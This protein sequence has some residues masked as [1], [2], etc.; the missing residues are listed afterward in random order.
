MQTLRYLLRK[1]FLQVFR[2]RMMVTQLLLMPIIQLLLFG[3]AATFEVKTSRMYVVDRDHIG[4][5]PS[6][7]RKDGTR[8]YDNPAPLPPPLPAPAKK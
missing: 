1:E 4:F 5:G 8:G 6:P 3:N 7:I 2:D